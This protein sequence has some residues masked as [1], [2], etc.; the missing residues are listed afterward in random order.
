MN[1]EGAKSTKRDR[2]TGGLIQIGEVW[3]MLWRHHGRQF[4]KSTGETVKEKAKRVLAAKIAEVRAGGPAVPDPERLRYA[5]LR[6]LYVQ[7][8]SDQQMK[9]M[10]RNAD[11][12]LYFASSLK[13]LD[14]F[15]EGW[16]VSEMTT[17][18]VNQ[19]KGGAPSGW[20]GQRDD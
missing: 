6:A 17:D 19:F 15:F 13:Q 2:G 5:H 9:S 20:C 7:D 8:Y 16:K 1:N 4:R 12:E 14:E 11:G 3:Y 18:A 10:R